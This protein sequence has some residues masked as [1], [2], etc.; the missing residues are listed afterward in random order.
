M[1]KAITPCLRRLTGRVLVVLASLC[2]LSIPSCNFYPFLGTKLDIFSILGTELPLVA[3]GAPG[4]ALLALLLQLQA[5]LLLQAPDVRYGHVVVAVLPAHHL[6]DRK[7]CE[8]LLIL[9]LSRYFQ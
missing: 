9:S 2:R 6:G 4:R 8:M 7:E 1:Y 5:R 3:H